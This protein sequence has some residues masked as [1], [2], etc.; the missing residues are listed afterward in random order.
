MTLVVRVIFGVLLCIVICDFASGQPPKG[1]DAPGPLSLEV[2]APDEPVVWGHTAVCTALA[3][4]GR[5]PYTYSLAVA[6]IGD[7][8]ADFSEGLDN[9]I[10]KLNYPTSNVGQYRFYGVVSD[11]RNDFD[12]K[13]DNFSVAEPDDIEATFAD[14][15]G[16]ATI[17]RGA[18]TFSYSKPVIF[19]VYHGSTKCGPNG[20]AFA[21]ERFANAFDANGNPT[22]WTG[23]IP[24]Q[25]QENSIF[26]W[27][28]PSVYDV[29]SGTGS[30]AV[31]DGLADGAVF[32]TRIQEVRIT[33]WDHQDQSLELIK[34]F[35]EKSTKKD[36]DTATITMTKIE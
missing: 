8:P 22:G 3:T 23:W 16:D 19:D 34:R 35:E 7:N 20:K 12:E 27:R 5:A 9:P 30:I 33:Y 28:A 31:W 13:Q 2:N 18:Q 32:R 24:E 14:K 29:K 25:P 15:S 11:T 36:A 4:G 1:G 10:R 17:S 6:A 21:Q 26:D